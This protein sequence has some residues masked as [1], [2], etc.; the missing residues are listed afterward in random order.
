MNGKE[1]TQMTQTNGSTAAVS[2]PGSTMAGI[3]GVNTVFTPEQLEELLVRLTEPFDPKVVEWR[4]TNTSGARGQVAAYADPRAYSDRLN[5]L[6]TPAGWTRDY[7]VQTVQ[8]FEVPR[9]D[10]KSTIITAKVM[11]TSKVT[12]HGLG[13]HCGTGEEWA[14]DENALTRA[15]AQAFK[16]ACSCFGLGRYFYDVPRTWVDLD[17]K[18]RPLQLPALPEWALPKTARNRAPERRPREQDPEASQP[19]RTTGGNGRAWRSNSASARRDTANGRTHREGDGRRSNGLYGN[20][21]RQAVH[22]LGEE[23]GFS[24]TRSVVQA[25]AGKDEIEAVRSNAQMTSLFEKLTDLARGVRRLRSATERAG[26]GVYAR[27]CQ[28]LNLPSD[29][30]DDI[31]SREVLRELVDRMEAAPETTRVD[32]KGAPGVTSADPSGSNRSADNGGP[33]LASNSGT[34]NRIGQLRERLLLEARRVSTGRRK[35]I[36]DVIALAS[37]GTF[38]F[39]DLTKLTDADA[40]KVESALAELAR[41]AV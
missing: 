9:K 5:E 8:N 40:E 32:D 36:G 3:P 33:A 21:L 25:V 41:M 31:P 10:S 1:R 18:N 20:E 17:E 24:L 7:T 13:A 16:R 27:L 19:T 30:I 23:V 39:A 29:A 37:K 6:F 15:E 11:V 28:E 26:A 2:A 12:I 22:E 38:G 4:V 35:G 34:G 14:V